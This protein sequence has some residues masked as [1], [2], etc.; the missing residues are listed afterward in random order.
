MR[1][2]SNN[3]RLTLNGVTKTVVEWSEETGLSERT[4]LSRLRLGWPTDRVLTAEVL[5]RGH[6][7]RSDIKKRRRTPPSYSDRLAATLLHLTRGDGTPLIPPDVRDKGKAAILKCVEWD[8]ITPVAIG[9][10]NHHSNIQPLTPAEHLAKT[11]LDVARIAKG[12]RL[13]EA[14]EE[15]RRKMLAKAGQG[16]ATEPTKK[17]P[18]KA[19]KPVNA[20][21][22]W[23]QRRW[24]R[25]AEREDVE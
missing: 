17:K 25:V 12:K 1:N 11:K 3:R 22:D 6:Y 10:T 20:K 18:K 9:G 21:W 16:W 14:Q 15:F 13:S 2:T 23:R 4:I 24:V 19:W 7:D 8:H 5:D